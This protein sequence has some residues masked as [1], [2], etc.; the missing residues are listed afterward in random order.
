MSEDLSSLAGPSLDQLLDE[1]RRRYKSAQTQAS[2]AEKASV[3]HPIQEAGERIRVARKQQGLTQTELCDLSGVGYS[4]LNKIESGHPTVR[5]DVLLN[6]ARALGL[7][8]WIG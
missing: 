6:V 4:T 7:K 2:M 8:L 1:I 5:L 3:L